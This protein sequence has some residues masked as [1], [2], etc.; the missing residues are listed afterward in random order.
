MDWLMAVKHVLAG[1][2]LGL[3]TTGCGT[4]I[5]PVTAYD[6]EASRLASETAGE[7]MVCER[8]RETG[9]RLGEMICRSVAEVERERETAQD[10]ARQRNTRDRS[11]MRPPPGTEPLGPDLF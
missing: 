4:L 11:G 6:T 10:Y 2:I 7:P 1:V 8:R 5:K 3:A 9:T